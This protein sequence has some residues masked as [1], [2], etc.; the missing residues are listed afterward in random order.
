MAIQIERLR[1]EKSHEFDI[2][3]I[4][5]N[6]IIE[7]QK[8]L[9]DLRNKQELT[10]TRNGPGREK[11]HL[12]SLESEIAKLEQE[13]SQEFTQMKIKQDITFEMEKKLSD[14]ENMALFMKGVKIP[15]GF[16]LSASGWPLIKFP[17]LGDYFLTSSEQNGRPV[18]RHSDSSSL[19][20][21]YCQEDETWAIDGWVA[22]HDT[23]VVYRSKD[24][25][26]IPALCQ[27]WEHRGYGEAEYKSVDIS[28]KFF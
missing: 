18:Y 8:T 21:L 12:E 3:K 11:E 2:L 1:I 28:F 6:N 15:T 24:A 26:V 23:C 17:Y 13:K 27:H 7:K 22:D 9:E 25:A 4:K 19:W 14:M 10:R 16:T 5:Q 20:P